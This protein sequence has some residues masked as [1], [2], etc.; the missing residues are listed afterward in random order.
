MDITEAKEQIWLKEW[1]NL[2]QERIQS[3]ISVRDFCKQNRY[4]ENQYYYY[5]RKLRTKIIK[6]SGFVKLPQVP[7]QTSA[8]FESSTEV[9]IKSEGFKN[10]EHVCNNF[11]AEMIIIT[12]IKLVANRM[13]NIID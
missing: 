13:M 12:S 10:P 4:T 8:V 11:N 5:L 1:S 9:C 6:D 2:I 3:G 7:T